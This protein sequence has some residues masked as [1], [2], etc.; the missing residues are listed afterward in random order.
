MRIGLLLPH[1]GEFADPEK[2]VAGS[3]RAEQLGFSSVWVRDH[4]LFTPH[5]EFEKPDATFFEALTVLTVVGARTT[6]LRL[7][8]GALIPFRH[9]LPTAVAISTMTQF[10]GPRLT[11]GFG[12]GTF[13]HEF[14]AVNLGGWPRQHLV[15][16]SVRIMRDVWAND[17]V[18]SDAE[19]YR[20]ANV[21]L[22]PRPV[23]GPV[24]LWYCGA[25][26]RSARLAAEFADGWLPGR[27][28]LPTLQSRVRLLREQAEQNDRPMPAVGIIPTTSVDPDPAAALAR[29]NVDGLLAWANG[30]KYWVTPA[31]GR[32]ETAADLAGVL[33]HGTPGDLVDQ[34]G[35]LA[36]AGVDEVV[37]DFRLTFDRWEEQMEL[38]GAEVLPKVGGAG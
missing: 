21:S 3:V 38:V 16:E 25:T 34:V 18:S 37:L 12:A 17:G 30:S 29:V 24:P 20:F 23:G 7:G 27:I 15:R 2:I 14:A 10:F 9:P 31:S 19:P 4:L 13:D 36:E 28:S 35:E 33:L 6:T 32:F 8:T 22:R 26:P 11:I 5:G 1:F